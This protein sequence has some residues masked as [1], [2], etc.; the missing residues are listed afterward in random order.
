MSSHQQS[1]ATRIESEQATADEPSLTDSEEIPAESFDT[2]ST[3]TECG[4][5]SFTRSGA[6]EWYCEGCGAVHTRT[7]LEYSEPGWTPSEERRTGPAGSV[8]RLTV[9]S[10]V[11]AT[12]SRTPTW[13]KYNDR[14]SHENQTLRHGLRELRALSNTLEA[15]E[16]LTDQASYLFRR[17]ADTG[18][19]VGQ[20][21]EAMAAA[22]I[23][24]T[25]REHH[26]PFPLDAIADSSP[27]GLT[28]I[29]GAVSKLLREFDL[30]VA[31]P[32]P[33]AFVP[34]FASEAGLSDP[35]RERALEISEALIEEQVHVGQSP[36]G[37]AAAALYA[38]A[39]EHEES[40][41]QDELASVAYVSVVTLSRQWQTVQDAIEFD[42]E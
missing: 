36:T 39:K 7:E 14:L 17:A 42:A 35:V 37:V 40:V 26:V 12:G 16:S 11:G 23:H 27:V 29:K 33:T 10:K 24:V 8:S 4:D 41:T 22:C 15:T 18:L 2:A 32:L 21:L 31:P 19:L 9:G 25:A 6:G 1:T 20:S 5:R 30:Q 13:A 28:D 3:C 38:A 34:R